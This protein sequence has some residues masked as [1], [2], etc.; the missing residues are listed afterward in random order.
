MVGGGASD[1]RP[2]PLRTIAAV[3]SRS[4]AVLWVPPRTSARHLALMPPEVVVRELP[5]DGELPASLGRADVLVPHIA[6]DRLRAVLP[7]LEGLRVIQTL[8]AGVDYLDGVV[9]DGV[10]L[11]DA[12]GVH[13]I[14]V[15]EWVLAAILA[16]QRELPRY[17]RQ[18]ERG[19]W[20]AAPKRARELDGSTVLVVGHGSIGRAVEERVRPF[21][22]VVRG[23]ARHPRPG[24]DGI[25]QLPDLLPIADVVVVLLPLTTHTRGLVDAGFIARMK[26]GALLVNAGRGAVADT[27]A[28]TEAVLA[29]RI[30]AAL[31]VVDPEPL[32]ADHPLWSAPGALVTPHVAGT[33][34]RFIDRGWAL[35]A[36]QMRRYLDG[37]PLRNVVS[38]GY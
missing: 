30:R 19:E 14:G 21:G 28:I 9:P 33:T 27:A 20:Q 34:E 23:V 29:G 16:M 35:V 15:S 18:Q 26:P 24:V 7:R 6:D 25:E 11:C 12:A 4:D 31:D 3:T 36:D 37:R 32:P 5:V 38:D 13:D 22:A 1:W 10:I 17:V 2:A 8:S